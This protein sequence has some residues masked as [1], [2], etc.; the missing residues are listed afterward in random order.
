[1]KK[2]LLATSIVVMS[3]T[4]IAAN[5]SQ[6]LDTAVTDTLTVTAKYVT[7]IAVELD[8][9]AI[10]FG[11]V[12]TDSVIPTVSVVAT[13][14]GEADE[15]FTYS[16]T[17]DAIVLLTGDIAGTATAFVTSGTTQAL[18]FNVGLDTSGATTGTTVNEIVTVS[19]IYD[20][21]ADTDT[22]REPVV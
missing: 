15:T 11:D 19:V 5:T 18:T 13:V 9:T 22:T 14:T 1:M 4:A 8:T 7:P 21:I 6:L 12:W 10:D 20:A 3:S 16:V 2:L 17:G